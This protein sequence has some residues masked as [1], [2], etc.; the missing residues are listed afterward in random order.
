MLVAVCACRPGTVTALAWERPWQR[1][2]YRPSAKAPLRVTLPVAARLWRGEHSEG[3][4][5]LP[6]LGTAPLRAYSETITRLIDLAFYR[7][8]GVPPLVIATN[9]RR[10]AAWKELV[11][12]LS[13]S[14][15]L[16]PPITC[17]ANWN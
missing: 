7:A 17:I 15:R 1:D 8:D 2:F 12:E 5:L 6:D 16:P 14:R 4:L 9:G 3:Y 11:N 10:A 13:R